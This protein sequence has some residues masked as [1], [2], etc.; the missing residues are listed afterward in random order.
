MT[1]RCLMAM[2]LVAC[3]SPRVRNAHRP[4]DAASAAGD[5]APPFFTVP[6]AGA[7][8]DDRRSRL[9]AACRLAPGEQG[10]AGCSFYPMAVFSNGCFVVYV[11]NPGREPVHVAFEWH[12]TPIPVA[13]F[14]RR[15]QR[16]QG[17]TV[18]APYD[19]AAGLPPGEVL[20]LFVNDGQAGPAYCPVPAASGF[21]GL[22]FWPV[23]ESTGI[24]DAY[25]V[26]TDRPVVAYSYYGYERVGWGPPSASLLL[27]EESWGKTTVVAT[28]RD[29][30]QLWGPFVVVIASEDDTEVLF[31]PSQDIVDVDD[32][33]KLVASGVTKR[34]RLR[35]G[36][37]V[38][39][40]SHE[41]RP[42]APNDLAWPALSG[43]V[44]SAN[45]PV[46]VLASS[47]GFRMPLESEAGAA[48]QQ[49]AP[50]EALGHEYVAA[51][52]PDRL[53]TVVEDIPWQIV[54]AADGIELTYVPSP[55]KDAPLT[56][57]V[58]Q[59][60]HFWSKTP[61]LVR[62]QDDR[63]PFLL[64]GYMTAPSFL[65][66]KD[67]GPG[68]PVFVPVV[69]TAQYDRSYVFFTDQSYPETRLVVVRKKGADGRFAD[70]TLGCAGTAIPRWTPLGDFELAQVTLTSAGKAVLPGCDAA[71]QK[72]ESP[73]PFAVTVWGWGAPEQDVTHISHGAAYGYP[74]GAGAHPANSAPPIVI[75]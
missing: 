40:A 21:R 49:L 32:P 13:T 67:D 72:I 24:G 31:R 10:N 64:E 46:G 48:H 29:S 41:T 14:G 37:F 50:R 1:S 69:P 56:L 19:E 9:P 5:A 25:H 61:F 44:V 39:F 2:A 36:E 58:G 45:K 74:A 70:V 30:I 38:Q 8:A 35:A 34:V 27:P 33:S 71:V 47:R 53:P 17:K 23:T 66:N 75:E 28:P 51:R 60:A 73:A 57:S 3:G 42:A 18:L 54:G 15:A 6:E 59:V 20:V 68:S 63:H 43:S 26:S 4:A 16:Q 52:Y 7:D 55:P 65:E 11:V 22:D 12:H 62:S